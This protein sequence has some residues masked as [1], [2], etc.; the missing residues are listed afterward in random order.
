MKNKIIAFIWLA[1]APVL[2]VWAQIGGPDDVRPRISARAIDAQGVIELRFQVADGY[3]ITDLKNNFFAMT[4]PANE[5]AVVART[6]FP[7]GVPYDEE[8]VFTGEFSVRVFLKR[9]RPSAPRSSWILTSPTRSARNI[10]RSSAILPT[11][12]GSRW[13]SAPI[14]PRR[15]RRPPRGQRAAGAPPGEPDPRPHGPRFVPAFPPGVRRRLPGQPDPLR[16]PG[17][18]HHHGLRGRPQRR[19]QAEGLHASPCSS[20]WASPWS[21]PCSGWSPPRPAR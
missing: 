8:S 16:L 5:H 4:L 17:H 20:S 19:A 2:A 13:R 11:R 12:A 7:A 14:S 3:H 10:P 9:S 15:R 6:V 18:P 1:I 21:I